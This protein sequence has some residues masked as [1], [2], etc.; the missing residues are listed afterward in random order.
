MACL[1]GLDKYA[2]SA[3]TYLEGDMTERKVSRYKTVSHGSTFQKQRQNLH[4]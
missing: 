3:P 2:R 4:V 1:T